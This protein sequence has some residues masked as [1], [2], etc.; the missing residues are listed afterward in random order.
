MATAFDPAR[1][2]AA[3]A[4]DPLV[5]E[6]P[7]HVLV[8]G[9][10]GLVGS[11]LLARLRAEGHRV[12]KAVRG[13]ATAEDEVAWNVEG[14]LSP[15]PKLAGLDA[16]VHLAGEN[17]AAGRWSAESKR[18][19]LESREVGTRRLCESLARLEPRPG[20][21]VSAS[22]I[23]FYG[24]RGKELLDEGSARGEGFLADVCAAWEDATAPARTAGIRTVNLRIG[25]VLSAS[26]GALRK[27]LPVFKA[28]VGGRIGDGQAYLSWI[29]LE[30]LLGAIQHVLVHAELAGPVNAVAP[31]AVTNLEFTRTLG[32]VLSRPTLV[33]VPAAALRLALGE[34]AEQTLLASTRVAPTRLQKSGFA[35]QHAELE[36]ALRHALGK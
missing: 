7:W 15:S 8:T 18:R 26:G 17:L 3:L 23:G 12:S 14:G 34:M 32:R 21:L 9:A 16:V 10:S 33:P 11:A 35:F 13:E 2:N 25:V 30:D 20:V 31:R 28:G 6:P 29:A 4:L 1:S 36:G 24:N 19:I 27:M 5:D 22:A